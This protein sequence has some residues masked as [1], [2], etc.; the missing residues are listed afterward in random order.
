MTAA[1]ALSLIEGPLGARAYAVVEWDK[2]VENASRFAESLKPLASKWSGVVLLITKDGVYDARVLEEVVAVIDKKVGYDVVIVVDLS[3][4]MSVSAP[5]PATTYSKHGGNGVLITD[6][7]QRPVPFKSVVE[8]RQMFYDALREVGKYRV[9]MVVDVANVQLDDFQMVTAFAAQFRGLN[10]YPWLALAPPKVEE[11]VRWRVEVAQWRASMRS[12]IGISDTAYERWHTIITPQIMIHDRYLSNR[13]NWTIDRFL[14]DLED[15]Y[16]GVDSV[17]LW[18][19]YPNIGVDDRSQFDMLEDV[20]NLASCVAALRERGVRVLLPYNPWDRG[21]RPSTMNISTPQLMLRYA[22]KL[23][24]D[25]VNGDTMF[26]MSGA[27]WGT[28]VTLEPE[29]GADRRDRFIEAYYDNEDQYRND[30]GLDSSLGFDQTTWN[31]YPLT[32]NGVYATGRAVSDADTLGDPETGFLDVSTPYAKSFPGLFYGPP[33]V[34]RYKQLDTRHNPVVC[35][36]WATDRLDGLHHAFF[37]AGGYAT[38]E[39]VWGIFNGLSD[40][41]AQLAKQ[42]KHLFTFLDAENLIFN[43]QVEFEPYSLDDSLPPG[44]FAST[45]SKSDDFAVYL[46]VNRRGSGLPADSNDPATTL[47]E[48][49]VPL[50]PS[51]RAKCRRLLC[52]DLWRGIVESVSIKI[53]PFG[54][55]AL[56]LND[57]KPSGAF[58]KERQRLV[59]R[60]LAN[61]STAPTLLNQTMIEP[62][63]T[64]QSPA[65]ANTTF[66]SGGDFHF[67]VHGIQVEGW[68]GIDGAVQG[69]HEPDVQFAWED[70]PSR[71]H[72]KVLTLDP[73]LIDTYPVTNARYLDFLHRT[74]YRPS[75]SKNFLSHLNGNESSNEQP[76]RWVSL[77]DARA[78]CQFEGKRLPHSWEWQRAA[79]GPNAS[80]VYPWGNSWE[81]DAVPPRDE[82]R[83]M[84]PPPEV[85]THPKGRS[86]EGV[87]DLVAT[88]W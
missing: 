56:A 24:A 55:S 33:L 16:G 78:F 82:G 88:I 35:D 18:H 34:S 79:Q 83:V 64:L 77:E 20:E 58:L 65:T 73:F 68:G 43:A 32:Y 46:F 86:P 59:M 45:L 48:D 80:Q 87:H 36:R 9:C 6:L 22:E 67:R 53:E 69:L 57:S 31:Y 61:Y 63:A 26:G 14:K 51:L 71:F 38:W 42:I 74:T 19:S 29:C 12:K 21:T 17:L 4:S 50:P 54:L 84:S 7:W 3:G 15:R 40:R 76:V 41:D 49:I 39:N 52:I 85:G 23:G 81:D 70:R 30:R 8:I 37:N 62:N 75:N 28:N 1:S 25:G 27:R 10:N 44:V 66:I 11:T 60:P 47:P 2:R 5:M 72:D 13:G